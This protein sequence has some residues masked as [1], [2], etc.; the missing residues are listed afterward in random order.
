MGN[1]KYY[2]A[3]K[4]LDIR[5]GPGDDY[6]VW[7]KLGKGDEIIVPVVGD[8]LPV[9]LEDEN[10]SDITGWVLGKFLE[11]EPEEQKPKPPKPA[12][13]PSG[14]FPFFEKNLTRMFGP[15]LP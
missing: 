3:T 6:D 9:L 12:E 8:W 4:R 2:T 5:S 15:P 1:E 14:L 13:V 10:G 11:E 7:E